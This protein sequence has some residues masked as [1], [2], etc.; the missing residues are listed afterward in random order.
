M[1]KNILLILLCGLWMLSCQNEEEEIFDQAPEQR[2]RERLA[3]F[4]SQLTTPVHGW[5][6]EYRPT[7]ET[8]SHLVLLQ[9]GTDGKVNLK[10]SLPGYEGGKV[11]SYRVGSSQLPELVFDTHT[12]FHELFELGRSTLGAEFE[13][14][15]ERSS[16]EEIVLKSKSDYYPAATAAR[17]VR[18]DESDWQ[19]LD[20]Q[21][22]YQSFLMG[23]PVFNTLTIGDQ[24]YGA[25]ISP[26]LG[27]LVLNPVVSGKTSGLL[28]S[29]PFKLVEGGMQ[30]LG[31]HEA[32]GGLGIIPGGTKIL[33]DEQGS[34]VQQ[35]VDASSQELGQMEGSHQPPFGI[36]SNA[37]V[38]LSE[39][40]FA[41][42]DQS[43]L[44]GLS[45]AEALKLLAELGSFHILVG[46]A[47]VFEQAV[48]PVFGLPGFIY[49][50]FRWGTLDLADE[51][52]PFSGFEMWF[53]GE[54]LIRRYLLYALDES[55]L[56]LSRIG[57]DFIGLHNF[58]EE[59][60][61]T[62][63]SFWSALASDGDRTF[64][65]RYTGRVLYSNAIQFNFELVD[66]TDSA[67][68]ILF[69]CLYFL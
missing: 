29:V 5:K 28:F 37:L 36:A 42:Y 53:E 48:Q 39:S 61:N 34:W 19:M 66:G 40:P 23:L 12:F 3:E 58:S 27:I 30:V 15:I 16:S 25:T 35:V 33:K 62:T 26:W 11:S 21:V 54:E 68:R 49:C 31:D 59:N 56:A 60:Y 64:T 67:N 41:Q 1:G 52:P 57:F 50:F 14:F 43:V 7:N 4:S 38:G 45:D 65:V 24:V 69:E 46:G 51:Q 17:M 63:L 10:T 20:R 6:M 32:P 13:F 44:A 22:A 2:I 18:A 8:G 55:Q 47:G 9:F